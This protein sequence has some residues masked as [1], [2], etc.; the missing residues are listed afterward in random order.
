MKKQ[1]LKKQIDATWSDQKL[2]LPITIQVRNAA[3]HQGHLERAKAFIQFKLATKTWLS[4]VL[5]LVFNR[6][7]CKSDCSD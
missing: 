3:I 6:V 7:F 4:C 5:P 1:L 2:D